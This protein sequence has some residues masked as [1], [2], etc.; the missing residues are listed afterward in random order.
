MFLLHR[1][2]LYYVL[3]EDYE[4]AVRTGDTSHPKPDPWVYE[5]CANCVQYATMIVLLHAKRHRT[6]R[7]EYFENWNNLQHLIAAYA[8]IVQVQTSPKMSVLLCGDPSQL[9]DSVE[10]V[11][12]EGLNRPLNVRETLNLL[13]NI[14]Q[15]FQR[16]TPITPSGS[17]GYA[18]SP[19]HSVLNHSS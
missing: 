2:V 13:R 8:I 4:K 15:N 16:H 5:S 19:V 11:L 10:F 9:L 12:E 18:S 3:Y 7:H 6:S 14:R 1:P 17:Q